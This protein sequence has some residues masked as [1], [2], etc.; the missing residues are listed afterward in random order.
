[1]KSVARMALEPGMVL[2][3]D[4]SYQD[5]ILFPAE[6]V[7]TAAMIER[8]KRYS[9]MC[10]TIK[11]GIDFATTHYEKIRFDEYFKIFQQKHGDNLMHY[12]RLMIS[13]VME[14]RQIPDEALLSIYSDMA[15]TYDSGTV[16]LDYLY[17]LVPNEDELTFTHCL[18]SALLG[19]TFAD[20]MELEKQDKETLILSCFYYD[21]GKL[22]LPYEILWKSGRL[23]EEE[24]ALV[25][26][27]PVIGYAILNNTSS[28]N[29][30]IKN[31]VI[32]HHERMDG[33]GYPYHMKGSGIDIFARYV[34]IID[35]YIA[36]ASPRSY[37]TALTPLQ[38]LDNFQ[39]NLSVYDTEILLPLMKRISDAQLGTTVQLSDDSVW[40]VFLIHPGRYSHPV[41]KNAEDQTLDLLATPQ[42]TIVK[43][44]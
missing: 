44:L 24:Y 7:L 34:A 32:M 30:R 25:K 21:I 38:I 14:G 23:S 22:R 41:L 42:L 36:M 15:S 8:L 11:E 13:F 27:H 1:M 37:R 43:N 3:E 20:W 35:T 4:V 40:D 29:Q 2:G 31:A 9:I 28:V 18:N 16:L 39:K 5:E 19:G 33:S 6:T 12:K 10:V 26:K 17:N